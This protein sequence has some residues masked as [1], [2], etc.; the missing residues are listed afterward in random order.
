[1]TRVILAGAMV[2]LISLLVLSPV[3]GEKA[4]KETDTQSQEIKVTTPKFSEG[5]FPCSQCHK[6]MDADPKRRKLEEHQGIV[7]HH[8]EA[9]RWCLDCHD[10]KNRDKLRL[11]AGVKIDFTELQRLCG[12]C[13]GPQYRDWKIGLHGKRIGTWDGPKTY[14]LCTECHDPHS[15]RFKPLKPLPPPDH[16]KE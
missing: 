8:D 5:I 9:N 4:T 10:A 6:D 7:L 14:L 12:Q 15:P 16:P 3:G 11:S 1:M 2:V 13:H